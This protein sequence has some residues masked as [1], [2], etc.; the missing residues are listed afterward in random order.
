MARNDSPSDPPLTEA[1]IQAFADGSLPPERAARVRRYLGKMPGEAKRIA[2]YRQ[3]NGQIQRS[4]MSAFPTADDSRFV[5]P[6]P[7]PGIRAALQRPLAALR[8]TRLQRVVLLILALSGWI[9]AAHVSDENFNATAVMSFEQAAI[10]GSDATGARPAAG[11]DPFATEF[12]QL[13]WRLVS[14]KTRRLGPISDA[15]EFDYRNA[16]GQPVVLLTTSAPLVIDRPRWMGHR[17]GDIRL[18]TWTAGGKRYILAGRAD[19][20]G[21]MKAAD[22]A[23]FHE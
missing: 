12:A 4:F 10:P 16:D 13:D 19:T 6:E 15:K 21:L 5:P 20:R 23:T 14:V 11:S 2:F 22:A 17:V 18:L 1:D 8:S 7:K 3:L 9:A